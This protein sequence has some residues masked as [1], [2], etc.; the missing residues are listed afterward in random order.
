MHRTIPQKF[1]SSFLI[2]PNIEAQ[3]VLYP[4]RLLN[5]KRL[6]LMKSIVSVIT[7]SLSFLATLS[8]QSIHLERQF[9]PVEIDGNT[10]GLA[11]AGGLNSPQF[12]QVDLN[13]DGRDDLFVFDRIG[14]VP[15]A[16][17]KQADGSYRFDESVLENFPAIESWVL[18][19][20]FNNNGAMDIFTY[21]FNVFL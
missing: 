15:M 4:V 21:N 2:L 7:I 10:I 11:F 12:S 18:L 5:L 13:R 19:R 8:S 20:D 14:D 9:P 16:F 17:L 3:P 6:D 1:L